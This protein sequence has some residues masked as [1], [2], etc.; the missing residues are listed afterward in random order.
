MKYNKLSIISAPEFE[1]NIIAVFLSQGLENPVV[2][3]EDKR[4]KCSV[5]LPEDYSIESLKGL[6]TSDICGNDFSVNS[7][8][9]EDFWSNRLHGDFKRLTIGDFLI[10][11]LHEFKQEKRKRYE[12][13][14][15]ILP[16]QAF[17]TGQHETTELVLSIIN[18]FNMKYA[19]VLDIGC[20]SGILSFAA[21]LKGA[22]SVIGIDIDPIAVYNARE[23]MSFNDINEGI[24]F[25]DSPITNFINKPWDYVFANIIS[26]KLIGLK[27]DFKLLSNTTNTFVFSG[28]TIENEEEFLKEFSFLEFKERIQKG[29]WVAFICKSIK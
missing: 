29:E 7:E 27:Q 17:G 12:N 19:K 25:S 6:F 20:G 18:R 5:F 1:D 16:A 15:I 22:K 10:T 26:G 28:I 14:I 2:E 11:P 8:I 3:Y 4:I 24:T 21:Y 23:N 9:I 13:E